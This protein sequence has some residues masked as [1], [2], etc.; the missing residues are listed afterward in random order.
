[1]RLQFLAKYRETGLL[2][3][4]IALGA[5]FIILLGPVLLSGHSAWAHHGE[6]VRRLGLHTH[7]QFWGFLGAL[8]GCV[9]GALMI[10]G[11]FFRLGVLFLLLIT[12][13]HLLGINNY[14][15][16]LNAVLLF[17]VLLGILFVG[18]G[19]YSVDKN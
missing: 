7:Y 9:G 6:A 4:R 2:F 8:L 11:L 19:K 15:A 10:F 17:V 14:R 3:M 13:I 5:L 16:N 12:L 1:M 18:P